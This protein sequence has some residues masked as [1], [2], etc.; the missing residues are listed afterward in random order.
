MERVLDAAAK[1][2]VE[3]GYDAATTEEIARLAGTSIGSVYQ[4]FPNKLAIFN[5]IALRYVEHSRQLFDTFMTP[6]A[7]D[8]PW[9][10]LLDG[11]IDAFVG[12]HR[13][14][15]GFRAIL[16][17]WRVSADMVLAND[18]VNR[19]FARRAE[20]VLNANA[21]SLSP[22]RRALVATIIIET[23]SSMLIVCV[24][25]PAQ[26]DAIVGETKML[27]RRYLEPIVA[28]NASARRPAKKTALKNEEAVARAIAAGLAQQRKPVV[29]VIVVGHVVRGRAVRAPFAVQLRV[30][31]STPP[32]ERPVR[33][34]RPLVEVPHHVDD[35]VLVRA[36]RV[37][38]GLRERAGELVQAL[39]VHLE[40]VPLLRGRVD[41]EPPDGAHR[42]SAGVVASAVLS[43]VRV[44]VLKRSRT[45]AR[46]SPL[47][48]RAQTLPLIGRTPRRPCVPLT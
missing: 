47:H 43:R 15:P 28:E 42:A 30:E 13:I 34:A 8:R 21:P 44:A 39:V 23:I 33:I 10:E 20:A 27:L 16:L 1:V 22:A 40:R 35:A 25:R 14:E 32:L 26:A 48:R 31:V 12:Y 9:T 5:A 37:R 41:A 19:E 36:P 29:R 11:A 6:E 17:N 24:R 4:F 45:D 38:A 18:D 46:L 2:F 3:R 7:I